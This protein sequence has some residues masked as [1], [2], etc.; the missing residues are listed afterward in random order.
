MHRQE[1]MSIVLFNQKHVVRSLHV[2]PMGDLPANH[3]IKVHIYAK[4][5]N[6]TK[7]QMISLKKKSK[8]SLHVCTYAVLYVATGLMPVMVSKL[9]RVIP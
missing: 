9:H 7:Q 3:Y 4:C 8:M 5:I 6:T 2:L 1:K